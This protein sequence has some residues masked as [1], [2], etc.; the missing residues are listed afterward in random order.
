MGLGYRLKNIVKVG[1]VVLFYKVGRDCS[2]VY[3]ELGFLWEV[4]LILLDFYFVK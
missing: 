3:D 2:V 1:V 4:E